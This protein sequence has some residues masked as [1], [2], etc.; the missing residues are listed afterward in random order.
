MQE[1]LLY[2]NRFNFIPKSNSI[3]II[4][5]ILGLLTPWPIFI[6]IFNFS[7]ILIEFNPEIITS[8]LDALP[9]PIGFFSLLIYLTI[10]MIR[11]KSFFFLIKSSTLYCLILFPV[12]LGFDLLR[13]PILI[14]PIIFLVVLKRLVEIKYVPND[15]FSFG[16]LT[17]LLLLYLT[18]IFSFLYFSFLDNDFLNIEYGRQIFGFE[19]WQ[20]LVVYSAICS[21]V[22]GFSTLYLIKNFKILSNFRIFFIFLTLASLIMAILPLRRAALLDLIIINLIIFKDFLGYL[23]FSKINKSNFITLGLISVGLVVFTNLLL[24]DRSFQVTARVSIIS[25][26]LSL[27]DNVDLFTLLF[28]IQKGFGGYSSLFL[29]LFIRNGIIGF[30]IYISVLI[31]CFYSYFR[32]LSLIPD[33]PKSNNSSVIIFLL[34][35]AFIGNLVNL[36]FG[37]PYYSVN[38]ACIMILFYSID[39]TSRLRRLM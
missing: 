13:I 16:F 1:K 38:F 6:D 2:Q 34:L 5:L 9:V 12:L 26:F 35:S 17:G 28:G 23:R 10:L 20:Y 15:G 8:K 39:C 30:L 33:I 36:N 18:N 24:V 29:E 19:T 4:F 32:N 11:T 21:I 27:L 22:C 7:I 31:Y 14:F 37:V 25:R 3:N